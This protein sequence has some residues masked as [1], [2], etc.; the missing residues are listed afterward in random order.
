VQRQVRQHEPEAVGELLH[1]RLPLAVRE[2]LRV[3]QRQR[4][5]GA[6]LPV[7]HPGSVVVVVEAE[8]HLQR[9]YRAEAVPA[10]TGARAA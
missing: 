3:Q 7:G 4:R 9:R 5:P 1:Q 6:G 10:L 8:L 2:Q